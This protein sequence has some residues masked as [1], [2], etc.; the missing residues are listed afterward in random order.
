MVKIKKKVEMT[1]PELITWA[2]K[3]GI[4]SEMFYS[5]IDGHYVHF[6]MAERVFIEHDVDKDETFTVEIGEEITENTKIPEMLEIFQDN[7]AT[8]WFG[9]SIEQV[10]DD[11]SREFWLKDGNTMTLIW[12]YG[13]LVGDE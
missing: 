10:K 12:K 2:W 4:K 13:E 6:D 5:N 11:F 8:Q 3:N 9:N 7:D 1:L